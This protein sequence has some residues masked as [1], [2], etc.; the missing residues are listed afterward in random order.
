MISI[1]Q[2]DNV[3]RNIESGLNWFVCN[4]NS[5]RFNTDTNIYTFGD[6]IRIRKEKW[7][8]LSILKASSFDRALHSGFLCCSHQLTIK[9]TNLYLADKHRRLVLC[10]ST[11]LSGNIQLPKSGLTIGHFAGQMYTGEYSLPLEVPT[12]QFIPKCK[13]IYQKE[14]VLRIEQSERVSME[15]LL[16]NK[17]HS[18]FSCTKYFLSK[19]ALL[20]D[21]IQL[22]GNVILHSLDKLIIS[23]DCKLDNVIVIAP[24]VFIEDN[25]KG[26]LQV[27]AK[28]K[29]ILGKNIHLGFPSALFLSLD[30]KES[31]MNS[32]YI[33]ANSEVNGNI[34]GVSKQ[35]QEL[36]MTLDKNIRINGQVYWNGVIIQN[37][38]DINGILYLNLFKI[39]TN[40]SVYMNYLK[41]F[42]L[43]NDSMVFFEDVINHDDE[44]ISYPIEV[45]Y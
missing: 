22:E 23:K 32:L 26:R 35:Q 38:S 10:G 6:T 36:I 41:D 40:A 18:F 1:I 39:N 25:F 8:V 20:L 19:N 24:E 15:Y 4:N 3:Y 43:R 9:D 45:C 30:K 27:F 7:G 5:L 2:H 33:G 29:I 13:D 12:N 28:K 42:K 31:H 16:G 14:L 11:D 34:V 17:M 44:S 37:G 21:K